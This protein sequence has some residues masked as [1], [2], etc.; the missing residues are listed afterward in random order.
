DSLSHPRKG[1]HAVHAEAI[2][3]VMESKRAEAIGQFDLFGDLG[4]GPSD[5][6]GVFDVKVPDEEWEPKHRLA[7]EREMLGL[8]VS[9][10][11]LHGVEQVLAA[12][13]DTAIPAILDG[14][15]TDGAQVTVGGILASVAR[16]VN[17]N[18]EPWASGQLEDLTG[19]IEVLF[20]PKTYSVVGMNVAEDAIVLIKARVARRDDRISLI[21]NDLVAPD[22]A[23]ARADQPVRVI[24]PAA[25]CTPP[26]VARL[27]DVLGAHPGT[28]EVQLSLV[29]G[30]RRHIL[31]LDERLRVS[32]TPALMGDLK[33][34]LGPGCLG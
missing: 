21:V 15:V 31:K 33:A 17:R 25:R 6:A 5:F 24:M 23:A 22:L 3:A 13:S 11:P 2:D 16:R 28:T 12:Q 34:L 8:Y 20:F 27:R 4:G 7:L 32:P 26:L 10:H 9:G 30:T 1:L 29:N 18:G 19:G 14:S